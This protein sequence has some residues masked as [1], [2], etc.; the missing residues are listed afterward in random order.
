MKG[1]L[2]Q[3][4][5]PNATLL[6]T[7]LLRYTTGAAHQIAGLAGFVSGLPRTLSEMLIRLH[8]MII[9]H[10]HPLLTY[11]RLGGVFN[12]ILILILFYFESSQCFTRLYS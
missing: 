9:L 2:I 12:F 6:R 5:F 7:C 3:R 1:A 4:G 11:Y 10:G 8:V